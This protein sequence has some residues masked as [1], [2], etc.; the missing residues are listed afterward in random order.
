MVKNSLEYIWLI[1]SSQRR[2]EAQTSLQW[3][4]R[5]DMDVEWVEWIYRAVADLLRF[6]K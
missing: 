1:G 3:L 2:E 6:W 5:K 4:A